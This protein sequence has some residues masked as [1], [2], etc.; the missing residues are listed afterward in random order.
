[1]LVLLEFTQLEERDPRLAQRTTQ[2]IAHLLRHQF[3]HIEDRGSTSMLETLQ[4]PAARSLVTGYF[5]VA[6]YRLVVRESEGWAGI[7]P[8]TER[9]SPVRMRLDETLVL[10]MLRRLWEEAVHDGDIQAHGT[11]LITLNQ[12][13]DAYQE[14]VARARRPALNV[15]AFRDIVE[16]LARRAIVGLGPYD[17]EAQDMELT[18]RPLVATV[19]G[20]DFLAA[21]EALLQRADAVGEE[22][23]AEPQPD[24]VIDAAEAEEVE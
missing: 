23:E 10:L 2:V 11:V 7:L 8:D 18:L 5:D 24:Q 12:A 19:A 20:D 13:Y 3:L 17:D 4:R 6:G 14:I 21:L 1:M 15:I 16:G 9:I 22:P